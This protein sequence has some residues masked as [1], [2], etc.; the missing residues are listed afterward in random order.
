MMDDDLLVYNTPD[1]RAFTMDSMHRLGVDG[2][3]VTVSW[4][5]VAGDLRRQPARLRGAKA[6]NPRNYRTDIWDRFDAIVRLAQ[7]DGMFVLF[8]VTGPGPR[9]AHPKRILRTSGLAV[10]HVLRRCR[11]SV[12]GDFRSGWR[13][14]RRR[15]QRKQNLFF[16]NG[17]GGGRPLA[18]GT[19][20]LLLQLAHAPLQLLDHRMSLSERCW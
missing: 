4:K 2:V 18:G 3:R 6:A 1:V 7:Q 17:L 20:N 19:I 13:F 8:N 5:F 15:E 14:R 12:D 16:G 11:Q 10:I 9:W